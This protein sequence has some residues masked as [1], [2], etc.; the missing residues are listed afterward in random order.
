MLCLGCHDWCALGFELE[1]VETNGRHF[2]QLTKKLIGKDV[3]VMFNFEC[4]EAAVWSHVAVQPLPPA[5]LPPDLVDGGIAFEILSK[6]GSILKDALASGLQLKVDQLKQICQS[7]GAELPA[8]GAGRGKT[9]ALIKADY[10]AAIVGKLF[11]EA[12]A[13]YKQELQQKL[14]GNCKPKKKMDVAVLA[15]ISELDSNNAEA[16]SEMKKH[17]MQM[18]EEKL[19]GQGVKQGLARKLD[20]E[21]SESRRAENF[22]EVSKG[23]EN[24]KAEDKE[25]Q[26]NH[27]VKQ[28]ELTPRDL[29]SLLPGRGAISGLFWARYNPFMSW[30]SVQYPTRPFSASCLVLN[31]FVF[32]FGTWV[33][34]HLLT[35]LAPEPEP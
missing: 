32:R 31:V 30:F 3:R 7:I 12:S 35:Y 22:K 19:Y 24:M 11:P 17:A 2:L 15:A 9:G 5:C 16:F 29:K 10:V 14:L 4:T 1:H 34:T 27:G 25:V 23:V 18:F 26:R 21:P 6:D 33:C 8:K 13:E 20:E 28:Y